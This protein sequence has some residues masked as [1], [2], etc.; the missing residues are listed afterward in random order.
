LD[1]P[2]GLPRA[3]SITSKIIGIEYI[4]LSV[5]A[6]G[7]S[8]PRHACA[9]ESSRIEQGDTASTKVFIAAIHVLVVIWLEV[10]GERECTASSDT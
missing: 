2:V 8:H 7:H 1:D 3:E 9:F 10:I 4:Y 5:L 6:R